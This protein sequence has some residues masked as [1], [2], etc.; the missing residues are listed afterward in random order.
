MPQ[1]VMNLA[2]RDLQIL[3]KAVPEDASGAEPPSNS[4]VRKIAEDV[5]GALK[6]SFAAVAAN[7]DAAVRSDSVE[8]AF[9]EALQSLPQKKREE[10]QKTASD[11][12]KASSGVRR[13]TFGRAGERSAEEHIGASGGFARYNEGLAPLQIDK[14]LLGVRVPQIT[15]PRGAV[16]ATSEGLL[17]P[18]SALPGNFESFENDFEDAAAQAER[19]S[20]LDDATLEEIYGPVYRNEDLGDSAAPGDFEEMAVTD[21]MGF[22]V[23]RVKCVDETNP[24]WLGSD[25]IGMAGVSV[26]EDGDTKK[27]SEKYIGG[28]FDDGASKSYSNW[29]YHWFSL[30]EG[31]QWPKTYSIT[32]L[33][34]EK[35][36][37]GLSDALN[38]IWSKVKDKVKEAIAKAISTALTE[39]LGPV[40]AKAIGEAVAWV[41]GLLVGWIISAFK[42]DIF[43]P[44]TARVTTP[45]MG[46]RWHYPNGTWG[47]PSSGT[48]TAHFYGHGGHYYVQY[49]WKFFA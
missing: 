16:R 21:K 48:R 19:S 11:L 12:V 26:D 31:T 28:G 30:R 24:E 32:L 49:Y 5:A 7:P 22:W 15:L 37:G 17:I 33:L 45:S 10:Y 38:S 23:T 35:D 44:F 42:D 34:A 2:S 43:P 13:A 47:N 8:A 20:V 39:Y 25:E 27:I 36:N 29:R 14:K 1:S 3:T 41:V 18:G 4:E 6:Y 40:I 46:A 9:K